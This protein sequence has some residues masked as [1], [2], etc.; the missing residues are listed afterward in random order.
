MFCFAVQHGGIRPAGD[1]FFREHCTNVLPFTLQ[2]VRLIRP[3]AGRH[4][5]LIFEI[6]HLYGGVVPVTVDQRLL[7][8]QYFQYRL[9]LRFGKLIRIRNP[10]LRLGGFHKQRR[11]GNVNRSVIGLHAAFVAFSIRQVLFNEHHV[12]AIRRRRE[13]LRV[14][15]QQVRSPLIRRAVDF[16]RHVEPVAFDHPGIDGFPVRDERRVDWLH[17]FTHD[18]AQRGIARGRHQIVTAFR[19]QADH[20]IRRRRRF[21]VYRTA[22]LFFELCHPVVLFIGL[23]TF[24]IARPG[25]NIQAAFS[26]T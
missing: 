6:A 12:P 15:H 18:Q 4:D 19:H 7:R 17:A 9:I 10:Q 8:A 16:A 14:V 1:P 25:D 3:G 26:L 23:T 24:D 13:N 21:D 22:G 2:R 5:A 11:V 20:L